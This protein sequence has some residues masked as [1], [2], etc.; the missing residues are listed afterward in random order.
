MNETFKWIGLDHV[1]LVMPEGG[2]GQARLFYGE[3]LGLHEE[4]KPP[5]L[6]LRGG[7]WFAC[8]GL[9]LHLGI[10]AN[11]QAARKAHPGLL[12]RGLSALRARLDQA[13]YVTSEDEP[14]IGYHR[15]Y[16]D[17]PFGNRLELMERQ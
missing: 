15:F 2:E 13:G 9:R 1:Q 5:H 11:F 3:I 7:C 4:A 6:A 17:Y 16:V 14:L 8:G 10:E 12:V